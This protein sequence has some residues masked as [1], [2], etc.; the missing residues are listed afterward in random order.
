MKKMEWILI[1]SLVVIVITAVLMSYSGPVFVEDKPADKPV[2]SKK[3]D[4]KKLYYTVI[5]TEVSETRARALEQYKMCPPLRPERFRRRV[6]MLWGVDIRDY[7]ENALVS[8]G[9]FAF[10]VSL[11]YQI[12]YGWK[13]WITDGPPQTPPGTD[14]FYS[15]CR[16]F[17]FMNDTAL[18]DAI[19]DYTKEMADSIIK[20]DRRFNELRDEVYDAYDVF[21]ALYRT[22]FGIRPRVIECL[23]KNYFYANTGKY[24]PP[25][26]IK[27]DSYR[28]PYRVSDIRRDLFLLYITEQV[29]KGRE[30]VSEEVRTGNGLNL[31]FPLDRFNNMY[32]G[33]IGTP[34]DGE[35]TTYPWRNYS[36]ERNLAAFLSFL[37]HLQQQMVN[38]TVIMYM[39]GQMDKQIRSSRPDA[40]QEPVRD[41]IRA[42]NYYGYAVLREFC[43]NP[44]REMPT[45]EKVG[46]SFKATAKIKNALLYLEPFADSYDIDTLRPGE[47][48]IAYEMGH[49]NY[50][51]AETVK[52]VESPVAGSDGYALILD[53]TETVYGYVKKAE[54][55]EFTDSDLINQTTNTGKG[56]PGAVIDPDGFV[57]IRKTMNAQ[58]EI[59]GKIVKKEPFDYWEIP[60][61]NWR[62]VKNK[63]GVLG[64]VYKDRIKEKINAGGWVISDE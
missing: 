43:E 17:I 12:L 40:D 53:R 50:Y 27:D 14:R 41:S 10:Y 59:I 38:K 3:Y 13:L 30:L 39:S 63:D 34:Q 61:S 18:Y 36:K 5:D 57:N 58:S 8:F 4:F 23:D 33:E 42:N 51:F 31:G 28:L 21:L 7:P 47:T 24:C 15:L 19:K 26:T 1:V 64:F 32:I 44:E 29:K 56:K 20:T 62:A 6:K 52:P 46:T 16:Q 25:P 60:G 49:D 37:V 9:D 35:F 11:K 2:K 48:F 54:V 55:K 22:T 45:L